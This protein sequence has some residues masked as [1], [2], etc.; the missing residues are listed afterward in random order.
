MKPVSFPVKTLAVAMWCRRDSDPATIIEEQ[1]RAG[2]NV[3]HEQFPAFCDRAIEPHYYYKAK[4]MCPRA[5]GP[6]VWRYED[7][8]DHW[9]QLEM[10]ASMIHQGKNIPF[11]KGTLSTMIPPPHLLAASGLERD[12]LV[13]YC[14]TVAMPEYLFGEG[15]VARLHD[16]VLGRTLEHRY[17]VEVLN[18]IA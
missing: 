14:G 3:F 5:L 1:K 16:P 13:L 18:P 8:A 9:D 7:V 2:W 12:G 15:F 4:Q 11:Q 6:R 17:G 10:S